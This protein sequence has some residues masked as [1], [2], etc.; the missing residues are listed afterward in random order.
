MQAANIT[1][2][3]SV[4][5]PKL[6]STEVDYWL[7]RGV[8]RNLYITGNVGDKNS[9]LDFHIWEKDRHNVRDVLQPLFIS[10]YEDLVIEEKDYKLA[11]YTPAND[12]RHEFFV[13][14]MFLFA[15]ES[16]DKYV[17]HSRADGKR[18]S[19]ALCFASE[20]KEYLRYEDTFLRIPTLTGDYLLGTYG[21][22]WFKNLKESKGFKS[23]PEFLEEYDD[24]LAK[25]I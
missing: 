23:T 21:P 19:K 6:D 8:L 4:V 11:F 1:N 10:Q 14:F 22:E 13:E 16:N 24:Y 5:I 25:Y 18:Y 17:Y 3:L 12:N 15:D 20:R 9:D 7:A 2:V